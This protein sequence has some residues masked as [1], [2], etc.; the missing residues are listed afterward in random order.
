MDKSFFKDY[1]SATLAAGGTQTVFLSDGEPFSG[2]VYNKVYV[3][4]GA[5]LKPVVAAKT[6][7]DLAKKCIGDTL[8]ANNLDAS[9]ISKV[10][11]NK[12]TVVMPYDMP[13][14]YTLVDKYFPP[15]LSP[16]CRIRPTARFLSGLTTV[17]DESGSFS[18]RQKVPNCMTSCHFSYSAVWTLTL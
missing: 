4:G 12:A 5:G 16:T 14:D 8:A 18:T 17:Q 7:I 1:T 10:Q 11:I 9:L 13:G 15:R 3:E 6:L 2:R